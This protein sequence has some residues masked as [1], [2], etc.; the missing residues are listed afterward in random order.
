MQLPQLL[1]NII[2]AVSLA[3]FLAYSSCTAFDELD[4]ATDWQTDR[5]QLTA[6]AKS[7]N[8]A[9]RIEVQNSE[10]SMAI[11]VFQI[12]LTGDFSIT[13]NFDAFSPGMG[14]G[15]FAQMVVSETDSNRLGI[16]GTS[17]GNGMMEAFV[18]Y[19][20]EHTDSRFTNSSSGTFSIER[21]NSTIITICTIGEL[22]VSKTGLFSN[23]S[24]KISFQVG[25]NGEQLFGTTGIT[26][27]D[28]SVSENAGIDSD[29]FDCDRVL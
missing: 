26:I 8:D 3:S 2:G 27:T 10:R 23:E 18:A 13:A 25:S 29:Y 24:L 9:L 22:T 12:G 1:F 15:G 28:F 6:N 11:E 19:P 21:S 16:C 7:E 4:C 20:F 14:Y 17:I 5:F